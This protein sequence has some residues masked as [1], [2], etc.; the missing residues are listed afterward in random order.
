[1]GALYRLIIILALALPIYPVWAVSTVGGNL[2][3]TFTGN[4]T[5]GFVNYSGNIEGSWTASGVFDAGGNFVENVTG[6]GTF[7]G[8]GIA[9]SWQVIGYNAATKA[10]SVTWTAPDNRG[11]TSGLANGSADGSVTLIVDTAT[12][13]ATG[14]FQG[15]FFTPDGTR[16]ITG[17]WTVQFQGFADNTVTGQIQGN[18]SGN[19]DYVGSVNGTVSGDWLVRFMPDGS[20]SGTASG[21]YDG[22]NI[23]VGGYGS[24]CICGTW[25]A[26]VT[27]DADGQF[28]LEGSWTHP[29]ISGT[30]GGS[31]GG[32]IVWY[33]NPDTNPIQANGTF[34]G[35]TVFT[36]PLSLPMPPISVAVSTSG[37]WNA[38]LPINP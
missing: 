16:N 5:G 19:A 24:V 23:V 36:V 2:T 18:F 1:M 13:I 25:I 22:G 28:R 11:P 10:I 14:A 9:G 4:E 32:P 27:R 12:G 8:V 33:I 34:S 37:N 30:L 29:V 15:Q 38:I 3:G 21:S 7:G 31:G 6:N 17:T 35:S 26:L 20:V